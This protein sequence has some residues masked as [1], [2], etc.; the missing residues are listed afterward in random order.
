MFD[1][2][3]GPREGFPPKPVAKEPMDD[4]RLGIQANLNTLLRD[5]SSSQ[6]ELHQLTPNRSGEGYW[7]AKAKPLCPSSPTP[8][9]DRLGVANDKHD[10]AC[11]EAEEDLLSQD[12][13]RNLQED[14]GIT[15]IRSGESDKG[16]V[17]DHCPLASD[18]CSENKSLPSLVNE[19]YESYVV[20]C[21]NNADFD[22]NPNHSDQVIGD[23]S[24]IHK[25]VPDSSLA[26]EL[27]Q[28]NTLLQHNP[29][30]MNVAQDLPSNIEANFESQP[31]LSEVRSIHQNPITMNVDQELPSNIEANPES[32]PSLSETNLE[33]QPSLSEVTTSTLQQ[34]KNIGGQTT[35]HDFLSPKS[36]S[37]SLAKVDNKSS[38]RRSSSKRKGASPKDTPKRKRQSKNKQQT[39]VFGKTG[40]SSGNTDS[41]IEK[42]TEVQSSAGSVDNVDKPSQ[43]MDWWLNQPSPS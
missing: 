34:D 42:D 19:S 29:V 10:S 28:N 39:S 22:S 2:Q 32:Q 6:D 24:P 11:C 7:S 1:W 30:T 3:P 40:F 5:H 8:K 23:I 15:Y 9:Q 37:R 4:A 12:S 14:I 36:R 20:T 17:I 26:Q 33:S 16:T 31:S 18:S 38:R 25:A 41:E 43:N 13:L 21:P 35:L 27:V